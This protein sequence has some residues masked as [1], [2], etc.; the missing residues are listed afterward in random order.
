MRSTPNN[1]ASAPA[2]AT[3]TPDADVGSRMR[4]L[5]TSRGLRRIVLPLL[6]TA[7][8][9]GSWE[10]ATRIGNIPSYILPAP[11]EI[12]GSLIAD[13]NSSL[14]WWNLFVTA[15][16]TLLGFA[17]GVILGFILGLLIAEFPA[18]DDAFYPIIVAFQ[19]MPKVAVAPLL[20]IWFGFGI[21]S[22][23][24]IGALLAFFPLL[25][26]TV[27]GL[28]STDPRQEELM[29]TLSAKRWQTFSMVRFYNALP[30]IIA[31]LEVA[32]VF[33]VI[34]AIVGEFVGARAGLGYMIQQRNAD[35][36]VPGIFSILIILGAFG[37]ILT[38]AV[39]LLGARL[40][41]WQRH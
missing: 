2:M 10:V 16:E 9:I 13:F 23:V 33:A 24:A 27:L 28:H 8:M 17:C 1:A 19:A 26:N 32:M 29:Q 7:I 39:K 36:D 5:V 31:G 41:F 3:P 38:Y 12:Y 21:G 18:I 40:V 11:S 4:D 37:A 15:S 30:S 35:T 6:A 20:L 22:K 34:G 14:M 25:V